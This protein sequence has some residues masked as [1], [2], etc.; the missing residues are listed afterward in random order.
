MSYIRVAEILSN[1]ND[2][3]FYKTIFVRDVGK[4]N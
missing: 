1:F 2:L 3:H 4:F